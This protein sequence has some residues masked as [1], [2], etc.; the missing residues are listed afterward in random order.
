M[1]TC[2]STRSVQRGRLDRR[3]A[4]AAARAAADAVDGDHPGEGRRGQRHQGDDG[5]VGPGA[6]RA[7]GGEVGKAINAR[8][9]E[10]DM[11]SF[12]YVDN[13]SRALRYAGTIALEMGAEIIDSQ[14]HCAHPGRGRRARPHRRR[15][16]FAGAV[17]G[18]AGPGRQGR[19]DLQLLL[20]QVR[21]H[22]QHGPSFTTR[23]AEAA[24]F[25]TTAVQSAKDPA[26]ANT[27]AYLAMKNQDWAGP[28]KRS[29]R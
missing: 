16:G 2:R 14:T 5:A 9:T 20:R 10:S 27:L 1:P 21:G 15:P 7:V 12:H 4:G 29:P 3:R 19:Q 18:R 13:V 22:G 24:E 17:Q 28:K 6:G 8:K 26:T 23:R 11:G 25:L